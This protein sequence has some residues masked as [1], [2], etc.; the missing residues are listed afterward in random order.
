VLTGLDQLKTAAP[1]QTLAGRPAPA[2][3]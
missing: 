3:E 2:I 1:V